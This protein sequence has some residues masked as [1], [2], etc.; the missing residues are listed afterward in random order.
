M[1]ANIQVTVLMAISPSR[2][3][4]FPAALY[5][6]RDIINLECLSVTTITFVM[7]STIL[8]PGQAHVLRVYHQYHL[9]QHTVR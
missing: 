9:V 4:T 8:K 2:L 5:H 3:E 6:Q 7:K 1:L